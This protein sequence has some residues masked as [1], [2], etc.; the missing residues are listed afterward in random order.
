MMMKC[1][2]EKN[3]LI[4]KNN[5]SELASITESQSKKPDIISGSCS[6]LTELTMINQ[7]CQDQYCPNLY[8]PISNYFDTFQH[9]IKVSLLNIEVE[10]GGIQMRRQLILNVS[11]KQ[12]T[13]ICGLFAEAIN[14]SNG[15]YIITHSCITL[16]REAAM[17]WQGTV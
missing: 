4:F 14:S 15:S 10:V 16:S 1:N 13:A 12:F 11:L 9:K 6:Q 7:K 5:A 3:A 17:A 8:F 2:R